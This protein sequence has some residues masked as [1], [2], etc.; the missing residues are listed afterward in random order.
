[1][2]MFL[3]IHVEIMCLPFL[4]IYVVHL[5]G[6]IQEYIDP[7]SIEWAT[8][9]SVLYI[10]MH[11]VTYVMNSDILISFYPWVCQQKNTNIIKFLYQ[12]PLCISY[13]VGMIW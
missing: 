6:M 9:R 11:T 2:P 3:L 4:H 10:C 7:K 13:Y 8:V 12:I 1:V 5:V